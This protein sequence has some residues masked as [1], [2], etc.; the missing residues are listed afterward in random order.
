VVGLTEAD[1]PLPNQRSWAEIPF[2][3]DLRGEALSET[4]RLA[5]PWDPT[6]PVVISGTDIRIGGSIDRLDLAGDRKRARVT[7]YKSGKLGPPSQLKGGSELQRC[8]YAY[9]V[10]TLIA[11]RPD[12]E[13]RLLYPRKDGR[14]LVLAEP[15]ATLT[16]LAGYL[17]AAARSFAAG[18]ALPGPAAAESWYDFAFALPG[19]AKE[20][21]IRP[22]EIDR[23]KLTA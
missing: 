23:L 1:A 19:G 6:V 7:D 16:R 3:G 14:I 20:T 11:E 4:A 8:L 17:A 13:A 9:A 22:R 15:E 2:G 5:L 10:K 12:V 21:R 18:K